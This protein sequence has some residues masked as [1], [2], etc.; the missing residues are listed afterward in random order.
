M[1]DHLKPEDMIS[2]HA[3]AFDHGVAIHCGQN[4]AVVFGHI[5]FWLKVNSRKEDCW[6][7]DTV[8]MYQ[9]QEDI[10]DF[11]EYLTEKQVRDAL[12]IL[13]DKGLIIKKNFNKN[14]FDHTTWY[15]LP[16]NILKKVVTKRPVSRIDIDLEVASEA[17][18]KSD[19]TYI[20]K[21]KEKKDAERLR[22][23]EENAAAA[24]EKIYYKNSNG[25][26]QSI[27]KS[28]LYKASL[29]YPTHVVEEAI[30]KISQSKDTVGNYINFFLSICDRI[31]FDEK[32]ISKEVYD[33]LKS[34]H[35]PPKSNAK[36]VSMEEVM[37]RKSQ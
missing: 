29:K 9:S 35:A 19:R 26:P 30:K 5:C 23:R 10:A 25:E 31:L 37:K 4:A 33:P 11:F 1:C 16:E 15:S 21:D 18:P 32:Q 2:G 6:K 13:V 27:T 22:T 8:W 12:K 34:K 24:G 14:A 7:E 3:L 28:E 20:V 36:G 17:T